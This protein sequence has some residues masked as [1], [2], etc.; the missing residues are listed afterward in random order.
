MRSGCAW[1]VGRSAPDIYTRFTWTII[2]WVMVIVGGA[3]NNV[4]VAVG[5]IVYELIFKI[6]DYAKYAFQSYLPFDVNWLQYLTVG[7]LLTAILIYRPE[8]LLREKASA[9]INRAKMEGLVRGAETNAPTTEVASE[10]PPP[11]G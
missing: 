2:P 1:M 4:G 7:I 8:G 9:T 10:D 11:Q 6:I 3:A 5:V